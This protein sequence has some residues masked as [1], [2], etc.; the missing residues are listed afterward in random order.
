MNTIKTT[1]GHVMFFAT[2][3]I[4]VEAEE[5]IMTQRELVADDEIAGVDAGAGLAVG[6]L[7][8]AVDV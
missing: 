2:E 8:A 7:V 6:K 1:T 4:I 5:L 3:E